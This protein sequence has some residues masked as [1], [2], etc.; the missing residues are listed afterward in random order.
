MRHSC[1]TVVDRLRLL[2]DDKTG[3]ES[4]YYNIN[5]IISIYVCIYNWFFNKYL[6]T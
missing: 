6:N 2:V 1:V 4:R 5:E 3:Y